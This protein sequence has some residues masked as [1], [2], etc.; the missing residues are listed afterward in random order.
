MARTPN[1]DEV[2]HELEL[3]L[4]TLRTLTDVTAPIY[5]SD[6]RAL[7]YDHKLLLN[8]CGSLGPVA[9]LILMRCKIRRSA[10]ELKTAYR[11]AC[12]RSNAR[13]TNYTALQ[14]AFS[15][16]TT[17]VRPLPSSQCLCTGMGALL[18]DWRAKHGNNG[19]GLPPHP[20]SHQLFVKPF[21]GENACE[22]FLDY[23]EHT[24]TP[25]TQLCSRRR[26]NT[27]S[28]RDIT[29]HK[30]S[31]QVIDGNATLINVY[32]DGHWDGLRAF[33]EALAT[34]ISMA[35]AKNAQSLGSASSHV[36]RDVIFVPLRANATPAETDTSGTCQGPVDEHMGLDRLMGILSAFTEQGSTANLLQAPPMEDEVGFTQ[37]LH[38]IRESLMKTARIFIFDG[39]YESN[40]SVSRQI[41]ERV[42]A[43]EHFR[44]VLNRLMEPLLSS[45][46]E[47]HALDIFNRNRFIIT[48]NSEY[49]GNTLWS[50]TRSADGSAMRPPPVAEPL[51]KTDSSDYND[52]L[53][54]SVQYSDQVI[55]ILRHQALSHCRNDV[56]N[57]LLNS[58]V[59]LMS[60]LSSDHDA[61]WHES[62]LNLAVDQFCDHLQSP[63]SGIADS[64]TVISA[65]LSCLLTHTQEFRKTATSQNIVDSA[66]L[67]SELLLMLSVTPEGLTLETIDRVLTRASMTP[68]DIE[69]PLPTLQWAKDAGCLDAEIACFVN[70][71]ASIIGFI[72][73]EFVEGPEVEDHPLEYWEGLL[74]DSEQ[75]YKQRDGLTLD[76]RYP[77]VRSGLQQCEFWGA[78]GIDRYLLHRIISEIALQYQT[79]YFRHTDYRHRGSV[80]NWRRLLT[81]LYH[82]LASIGHPDVHTHKNYGVRGMDADGTSIDYWLFLYA[83]LYRQLME[84]P[85]LRRI[86]RIMGL[87]DLNISLLELFSKPWL[88]HTHLLAAGTVGLPRFVDNIIGSSQPAAEYYINR[89][90]AALARGEVDKV[91][92]TWYERFSK[93]NPGP[94]ID[95]QLQMESVL[96][97]KRLQTVESLA[98][99]EAIDV[100]QQLTGTG[101]VFSTF[102]RM[103]HDPSTDT[104]LVKELPDVGRNLHT[105]VPGLMSLVDLSQV[106]ALVQAMVDIV[107]RP[108]TVATALSYFGT[109]SRFDSDRADFSEGYSHIKR[110][111]EGLRYS[112]QSELQKTLTLSGP[113][114]SSLRRQA[115]ARLLLVEAARISLFRID[116]AGHGFSRNNA[117]GRTAV[118]LAI[119]LDDEFRQQL[120][121]AQSRPS[122]YFRFARRLADSCTRMSWQYPRDQANALIIETTMLRSESERITSSSRLTDNDAALANRL[123]MAARST[124]GRAE[125]VLT[126]PNIATRARLRMT[127]ERYKL[128]RD[129]AR[130]HRRGDNTEMIRIFK[131]HA[132][133]DMAILR[134]VVEANDARPYWKLIVGLQRDLD[135]SIA[136]G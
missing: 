45:T 39:V 103:V 70:S 22:Q 56:V 9:R 121:Q 26:L 43:D 4:R 76:F 27:S 11:A 114:C 75:R 135:A 46:E 98:V 62:E 105:S 102:Q 15:L 109:L 58:V 101:E 31:R 44:F 42:I 80:R 115:L 95:A 32:A 66:R 55:R 29:L 125:L 85:A 122:V 6:G 124:I 81:C 91:Y 52:M 73:R 126:T 128:N 12:E 99:D 108:A 23:L 5:L 25:A 21:H 130:F 59:P 132:Q 131:Q 71:A 92:P 129:L 33:S 35:E 38:R 68:A 82:G 119:K 13:T 97:E 63:T 106:T 19:L 37:T 117:Q 2:R 111:P 107:G 93:I 30:V 133:Y 8:S 60:R 120:T 83:K 41:L 34:E 51:R 86:S 18:D 90:R 113:E 96:L 67:W 61:P 64:N 100:L 14:Y 1:P 50:L 112:I 54:G 17:Q 78:F 88:L 89:M 47:P 77:E 72:R 87:E 110:I 10:K 40:V 7:A 48:S 20:E 94:T 57:Q 36:Q 69:H 118:R 49:T 136:R 65:F 53:K 24:S 28:D 123:L 116:P 127:L 74:A 3:V 84:G 104:G 134:G 79:T 16:K